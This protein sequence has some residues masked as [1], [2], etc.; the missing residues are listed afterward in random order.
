[1]SRIARE[2]AT[3]PDSDDDRRGERMMRGL[4]ASVPLWLVI[5]LASAASFV[6]LTLYARRTT[7][8]LRALARHVDAWLGASDPEPIGLSLGNDRRSRAWVR[9]GRSLD[10]LAASYAQR[11]RT[12]DAERPWRAQLVDAL[13]Q[14]AL[15]FDADGRLHAANGS[16]CD[17]MGLREPT[18]GT[19]ILET[20]A[21]TGIVQIAER[22]RESREPMTVDV[23]RA[24]RELRVGVS[25]VGD[26]TLIVLSDR[27]RERQIEDLRRDFVVNAS[28]ELKTP[29]TA[30]QTLADAITV[31]LPSDPTR[32]LSLVKRLNDESERLARLVNELLDLRRL[33]VAG[34]LERVPVDLAE[35]VRLVVAEQLPRAEARGVGIVVNVPESAPIAGVHADLEA[36][37]KNLVSN[38]VK[39]NRDRGRVEITLR[40]EG[41]TRVLT[42]A[43]TGIGIRQ[44]DLPRIFERFY[45]VDTARSRATGGT[46]LGLSIVRHAVERHGGAVKVESALGDGTTF[47]VTLPIGSDG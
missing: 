15:L 3:A 17:L 26:E 34:P 39:Y 41:A 13:S 44:Q 46:G 45:R 24:G 1:M 11:A 29:V 19:T 38:A 8:R 47:T 9:L 28:H 12:L 10:E 25:L 32:A 4:S 23:E 16:A 5:G 35:L 36:I 40:T 37:V 33:E 27:T 42:V 20:T 6:T 43:D 22:V 31:T 7:D 14:P 30:I 2:I 18:R 21:S